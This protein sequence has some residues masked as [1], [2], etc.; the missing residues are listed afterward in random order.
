M[1]SVLKDVRCS[2]CGTI[3]EAY[4][5]RDALDNDCEC[6]KCG[7]VRMHMS[8]CNG[9][10]KSRWRFMDWGGVSSKG[11]VECTGVTAEYEDGTP[12]TD[13]PD[14]FGPHSKPGAT[15]RGKPLEIS[16]ERMT[17]TR[18]KAAFNLRHKKGQ[19]PITIDMGA[20]VYGN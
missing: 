6:S 17:A 2:R 8:I 13:D 16:G 12:V 15:V 19:Q 18:D 14:S 1:S 7:C 5:P 10:C 3:R 4:M 20:K 9:G 11:Y